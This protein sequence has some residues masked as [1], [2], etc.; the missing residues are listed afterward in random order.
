MFEVGSEYENLKG[1]YRVVAKDGERITIRWEDGSEVV[2]S[3]KHQ[4]NFWNICS[5]RKI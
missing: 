2:T 3:E 5:R 4:K 1:P